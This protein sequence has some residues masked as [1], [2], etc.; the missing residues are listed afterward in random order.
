MEEEM[1]QAQAMA[2]RLACAR[3]TSWHLEALQGSVERACCLVARSE[4][5]RKAAAHAEI[6]GL[7]AEVAD[8]PV[9]VPVLRDGAGCVRE[10]MMAV[11]RAADWIVVNSRRQLLEYLRARDGEAAAQEMEKH[12]RVLLFM[13][14]L[15]RSGSKAETGYRQDRPAAKRDYRVS[16]T[17]FC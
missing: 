17:C 7:L 5:D 12:L 4:W 9:L 6:F 10:L 2:A 15:A 1:I 16:A 14:R 13:F 11:G 8:D 3:M